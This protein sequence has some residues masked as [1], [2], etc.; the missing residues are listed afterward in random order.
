[1]NRPP[2]CVFRSGFRRKRRPGGGWRCNDESNMDGH[3]EAQ[4]GTKRMSLFS[5]FFAPFRGQI[6]G[7]HLEREAP[8]LGSR[9]GVRRERRFGGPTSRAFKSNMDGHKEAQKDTK[10]MNLF[11]WFFVPF[12]GQILGAV[13]P[14]LLASFATR[15]GRHR[16]GPKFLRVS[17]CPTPCLECLV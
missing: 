17:R 3:K 8:F 5:W 14:E 7:A 12:R 4:K 6:P 16:T 13:G 15:E 9:S 11:S 1:M 10:R 2:C